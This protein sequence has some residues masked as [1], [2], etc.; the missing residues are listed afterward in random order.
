MTNEERNTDA[1]RALRRQLEELKLKSEAL[2]EAY[3]LLAQELRKRVNEI[4]DILD[5]ADM[6]LTGFP[7]P[8]I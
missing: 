3:G 2:N 6:N 5:A 8:N 1:I 7:I 4:E